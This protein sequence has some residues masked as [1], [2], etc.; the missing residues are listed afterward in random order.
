MFD[1]LMQSA[2]SRCIELMCEIV[3]R[4]FVRRMRLVTR[5]A[6]DL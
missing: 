1:Q 3:R 2:Q 5:A 4:E 6:D